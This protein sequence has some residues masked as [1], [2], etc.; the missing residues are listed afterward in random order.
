MTGFERAVNLAGSV[1]SLIALGYLWHLFGDDS[2]SAPAIAGLGVLPR[3]GRV[4]IDSAKKALK[5][6]PKKARRCGFTAE[7]LRRGMQVE[8]EHW[9]VTR[10][11]ERM[12]AMIAAAHLCERLD[13]YE[14]LERR[15][16]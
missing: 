4:S 9:N 16:E 13:Y 7:D 11:S 1:A 5:K 8:R 14:R 10:G 12:T 15:V 6:L 3:R 2:T